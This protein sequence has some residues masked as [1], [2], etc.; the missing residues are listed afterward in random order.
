[1]GGRCNCNASASSTFEYQEVSQKWVSTGIQ[2]CGKTYSAELEC[3]NGQWN[4]NLTAGCQLGF[5]I[6]VP[7]AGSPTSAI[8]CDPFH[9]QFMWLDSLIGGSLPESWC[10]EPKFLPVNYLESLTVTITA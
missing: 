7:A 1:M 10:C 6:T 5:P 3:V 8:T 4:C 2:F 9:A